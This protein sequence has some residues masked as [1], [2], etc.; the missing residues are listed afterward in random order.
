MYKTKNLLITGNNG[1]VG[2]NL[3]ESFKHQFTIYGIDIVSPDQ[4]GVLKTFS[5]ND[6]EKIPQVDTII[7][8][9]GKAHDVK[10]TSDIQSYFDIN[11]DL[12]SKIFNYF[13]NSNADKFIFFSSVK[14]VADTVSGDILKEGVEPA[15]MTAYGQSKLEAER[16]ILS[17]SIPNDKK[18]FILRPCMIHGP[19]NK[20]N[21]NLLYNIVQKGFPWPLGSFDNKRSFLSID[22]LI[23][24]IQELIEKEIDSGIFQ[25]ADD[26][27]LSTN[28]LITL[29]ADSL[30]KKALILK[31]PKYL[32]KSIARA[33]DLMH[34]PLNSERL[35]KLTESY[36]VSNKKLKNVLSI[37]QMPV[38]AQEGMKKTL[39]S[40]Q[41]EKIGTGA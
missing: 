27:P 28:Q 10:N 18:V 15:P 2:S 16:Y 17:K 35:K 13:L 23:F 29:I 7:H 3:V 12:T 22:N 11:T 25:V 32:I 1:F 30:N 6:L 24:V 40:F 14:A 37:S 31:T 36:V 9:A 26:E 8:L 21:L 38:L 4:K 39:T 19:G 41:K 34:L 33:G 20:G 5:W